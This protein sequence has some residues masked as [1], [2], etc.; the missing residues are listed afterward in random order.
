MKK[1]II[2]G[3][4][5]TLCKIQRQKQEPDCTDSF[6]GHVKSFRCDPKTITLKSNTNIH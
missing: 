1:K 3:T 4:E 2:P 6:M 5:N